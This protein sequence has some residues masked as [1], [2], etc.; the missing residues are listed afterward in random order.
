MA[1]GDEGTKEKLG[2][3]ETYCVAAAVPREMLP[4]SSRASG[5]LGCQKQTEKWIIDRSLGGTVAA[6]SMSSK[7]FKNHY[8]RRLWTQALVTY[9]E[10]FTVLGRGV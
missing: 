6:V 4:K 5:K 1:G 2:S 7:R 3:M 9:P 10:E 8:S